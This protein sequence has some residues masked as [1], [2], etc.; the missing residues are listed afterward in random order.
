LHPSVICHRNDRDDGSRGAEAVVSIAIPQPVSVPDAL[1]LIR[2]SDDRV[3]A[4]AAVGSGRY[5]QEADH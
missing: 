1:D 4:N 3:M 2:S 5:G